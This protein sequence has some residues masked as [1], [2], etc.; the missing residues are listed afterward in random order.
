MNIEKIKDDDLK[1]SILTAYNVFI[2]FDD[3]NLNDYLN[4]LNF[5]YISVNNLTSDTDIFI[6]SLFDYKIKDIK[7]YFKFIYA[8]YNNWYLDYINKDTI[9]QIIYSVCESDNLK[10]LTLIINNFLVEYYCTSF[11]SKELYDYYNVSD[12]IGAVTGYRVNNKDYINLYD[13][14]L[15][16]IEQIYNNYNLINY[17]KIEYFNNILY[18]NFKEF[19]I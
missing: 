3:I 15:D 9:K 7:Q 8:L 13:N 10:D 2:E 19:L 16:Y 17:P 11:I 1:E 4:L 12:Y 6:N 14:L 18:N 5:N